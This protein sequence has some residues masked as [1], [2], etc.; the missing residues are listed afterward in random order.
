MPPANAGVLECA[1]NPPPP[2]SND[3][4]TC[5]RRARRAG[6]GPPGLARRGEGQERPARTDALRG[7]GAAGGDRRDPTCHQPL[8]RR[9]SPGARDGRGECGSTLR[10]ERRRHLPSRGRPARSRRPSRHDRH[11]PSR[12][13]LPASRARNRGGARGA[14]S[15]DRPRGQ[16]SGRRRRVSR[17]LRVGAAPWL[18]GHPL[19]S[20]DA[21][22]LRG[23]GDRPPPDRGAPVH[24][25]TG[26]APRDVRRP[27]G[28]RDR[29]RATAR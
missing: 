24:G 21:R 25:A 9:H 18:P 4:T 12:G 6:R 19:R 27:G 16:P 26:R 5:R 13:V 3:D 2:G 14:G 28:H 1:P 23:R 7:A 10:V 29:E 20:S 22:I 8:A 17:E 15:G 11:R